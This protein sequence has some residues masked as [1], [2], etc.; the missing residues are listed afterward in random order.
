MFKVGDKVRVIAKSNY[1]EENDLPVGYESVVLVPNSNYGDVLIQR[2]DVSGHT[3][4]DA[5]PAKG[6]YVDP[7]RLEIITSSKD[8][9]EDVV[10][11]PSHYKAG[12][13]ETIDF[14]ESKKLDYHLGNV[15]KYISRAGKK[16]PAKEIQDLEKAAWYLARKIEKM[17][18][19][20]DES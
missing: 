20:K 8:T 17:K 11:H 9:K 18:E 19:A 10:N 12:G 5:S 14:I 16:D 2:D 7:S 6:W 3:A 1:S 4:H 13:I 15:V